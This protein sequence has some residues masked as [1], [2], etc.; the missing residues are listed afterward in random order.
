MFPQAQ[1][2]AG[3]SSGVL[4]SQTHQDDIELLRAL[5]LLTLDDT[6]SLKRSRKGKGH[7]DLMTDEEMAFR[8]YTEEAHASFTF[9]QD[10]ALALRLQEEERSLGL[11][12]NSLRFVALLFYLH[13]RE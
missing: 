8:I 2:K 6:E 5:A 13:F 1:P 11:T 4:R 10:R 3:S 12:N 7:E 9:E